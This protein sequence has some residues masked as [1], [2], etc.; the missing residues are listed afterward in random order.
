MFEKIGYLGKMP[1]FQFKYFICLLLDSF[2]FYDLHQTN[3]MSFF[4]FKIVHPL[5]SCFDG[6]WEF[7]SLRKFDGS[8]EKNWYCFVYRSWS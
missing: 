3:S 6:L 4:L 1:K 8:S 5:F 2:Q 7:D